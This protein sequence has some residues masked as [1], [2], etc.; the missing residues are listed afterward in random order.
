MKRLFAFALV[1]AVGLSACA[2]PPQEAASA[3]STRDC[4][5][6][7]LTSFASGSALLSQENILAVQRAANLITSQVPRA[8]VVAGNADGPEAAA[9]ATLSGRR[10]RAVVAQLEAD[11]VSAADIVMRDNGAREPIAEPRSGVPE[12]INRDTLILAQLSAA[13]G[14]A[15]CVGTEP[16]QTPP[17]ADLVFSARSAEPMYQSNA[18]LAARLGPEW[19]T[20]LNGYT[21]RI[22]FGVG[23][24]F[25]NAPPQAGVTVALV[26][27]I[28]PGGAVRAW[29]IDPEHG[30]SVAMTKQILA[31][32]QFVPP[33]PVK[34]GPVVFA[35]FFVGWGGGAPIINTQHPLPMPPEWTQGAPGPESVPDGVFARIWP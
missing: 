35:L 2:Q 24:I 5:L 33:P 30:L 10:A 16:D 25:I 8:V 9:D 14:Q 6:T 34:N 18:T 19:P 23:P 13:P 26:V 12:P 1:L 3:P 31:V 21:S 7:A 17:G 29:L 4:E 11:G 27:G 32:P 15:I 20:V 28:K 22:T